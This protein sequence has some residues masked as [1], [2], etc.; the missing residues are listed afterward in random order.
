MKTYRLL[1]ILL[2]ATGIL[3][4]VNSCKKITQDQLINGLWKVKS[5]TVDTS[6]YNYL[7]TL[8]HFADGDDCC[9][10]KLDFEKD[11]IVI[12]YYI[13]NNDLEKIVA[14]TW[15]AIDY[16]TVEVQVDSFM[17]G[18]FEINR[19]SPKH[20]KLTGEKNHL[21]LFDGVNPALDTAETVIDMFKI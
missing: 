14:G 18:S 12:A 17:D 13:A 4:T 6:S 15:E 3:L 1:S 7:N 9:A 16:N 10:Y 20:W 8:N 5:V 21:P 2:I 19:P 11:N